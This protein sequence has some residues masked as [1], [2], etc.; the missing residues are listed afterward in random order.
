MAAR[1]Q[2]QIDAAGQTTSVLSSLATAM[3]GQARKTFR[4]RDAEKR[5]R[6]RINGTHRFEGVKLDAEA[7]GLE[8]AEAAALEEAI[9]EAANMAIAKAQEAARESIA[10][11]IDDGR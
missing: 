6:V 1:K 3:A 8:A 9:R 2:P 5:V 10:D 11:L 7:L 4:G